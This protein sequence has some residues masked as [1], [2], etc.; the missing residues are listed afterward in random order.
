MLTCSS[1]PD[2]HSPSLQGESGKS[3][4]GR[5]LHLS[6]TM[7]INYPSFCWA[8]WSAYHLKQSEIGLLF[9]IMNSNYFFPIVLRRS[10]KKNADLICFATERKELGDQGRHHYT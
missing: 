8:C 9:F 1:Y 3:T 4:K 2:T 6:K 5:K 10:R 7:N